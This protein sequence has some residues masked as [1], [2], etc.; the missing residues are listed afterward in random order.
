MIVAPTNRSH[1]K[2]KHGDSIPRHRG[3]HQFSLVSSSC[4]SHYFSQKKLLESH[5]LPQFMPFYSTIGNG[6]KKT[7]WISSFK[8]TSPL[9]FGRQLFPIS[10]KW[11]SHPVS[12]LR[13]CNFWCRERKWICGDL[14]GYCRQSQ[15]DDFRVL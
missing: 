13:P 3:V 4:S 10:E 8:N 1:S 14:G 5:Q 7:P 9:G 2:K 12:H 6:Q 15:S 11:I